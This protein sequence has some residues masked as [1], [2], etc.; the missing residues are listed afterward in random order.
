MGVT[1]GSSSATLPSPCRRR[2]GSIT[3]TALA[4]QIAAASVGSLNLDGP[5]LLISNLVQQPVGNGQ[6]AAFQFTVYLTS[7][8]V[9]SQPVV[10]ATPL[11][12][13]KLGRLATSSKSGIRMVSAGIIIV[14]MINVST[15]FCPRHFNRDSA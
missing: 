1:R 2:F 14:A 10:S 13:D 6:P 15:I 9:F 8:E 7:N 5:T 3:G 12:S 4:A 11:S